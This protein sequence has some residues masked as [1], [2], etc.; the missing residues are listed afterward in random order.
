MPDTTFLSAAGT[1]PGKQRSSMHFRIIF[2]KTSGSSRIEDNAELQ[3]QGVENLVRLEARKENT[4]GKHAVTI[5]DL[6]KSS[7]RMR[8]SRI[9]VGEVRGDEV[10]DMLQAIICTI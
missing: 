7:L 9:I 6:I 5:R 4:E 10:V 3:I 1:V 2:Q 8:P